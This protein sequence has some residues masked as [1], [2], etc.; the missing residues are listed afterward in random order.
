MLDRAESQESRD[1]PTPAL[2]FPNKPR[3]APLGHRPSG[4]WR[5]EASVHEKT[6]AESAA[7]LLCNHQCASSNTLPDDSAEER[8]AD[9]PRKARAGAQRRRLLTGTSDSAAL[10]R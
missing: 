10:H 5:L 4:L 2:Q 3:A 6:V 9:S 8:T 1:Y 7:A